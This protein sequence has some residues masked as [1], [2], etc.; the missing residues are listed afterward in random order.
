VRLRS[1]IVSVALLV[2]ASTASRLAA[3]SLSNLPSPAEAE[4]LLD[5]RPDLVALLQQKIAAS[6]LTPDQVRE[7]LQ[8]AGYPPSLLDRILGP[9][10]GGAGSD[11]VNVRTALSAIDQLGIADSCDVDTTLYPDLNQE[12]APPPPVS[13]LNTNRLDPSMTGTSTLAGQPIANNSLSGST[14]GSSL[15]SG[16]TSSIALGRRGSVALGAGT[17]SSTGDMNAV[18]ALS[19]GLNDT[20]PRYRSTN[21]ANRPARCTSSVYAYDSA[22]RRRAAKPGTPLKI[23]GL[24]LFQASSNQFQPNLYGPIDANYKL[25]PGDQL[26]LILTGDVE[27][28]RSLTVTREGFIVLPQVGELNVANLTL[29]DLNELLYDR[30]GKVYSGIKRGPN[31]TTHFSISVSRLRSNQ[32]FVVGDVTQPGSY[33]LSSAG[34]TLSALYAARGPTTEGSM[35]HIEIRRAGKVIDSLDVYDYLLHGDASHDIRL[36]TGDIVFVPVHGP[37]IKVTGQVTRPAIYEMRGSETLADAI[38]NAGGYTAT[39]FRQRIQITRVV[40]PSNQTEPGRDRITMDVTAAAS[41]TGIAPALALT[42]GDSIT[43][44]GISDQVRDRITVS[45]DVWHA[46]TVGFAPGLRLSDAIRLAGGLKPDAYLGEVLIARLEPDSTRIQLRAT[47][48]DSTGTPVEDVVLQENDDIRIFA[49]REF[50]A[51]RYVAITGA[52]RHGGR[53]AYHEGMTMRDLVLLAGGLTEGAYLTEAEIAR[54][55]ENRAGG[56]TATSIRVP[57]DST[58]LFDRTPDGRWLGPPGLP[59]PTS[60]SPAVTLT[61]YDNVLI[62]RQP[63]FE[64]QRTVAIAGEVR[65]PGHYALERK[66]ERISDLIQRSGGLTREGYADGI[67]LYRQANRTGRIGIDLPRVLK[68]AKDRDNLIVQ[69]G[70]SIYIPT[71]SGIVRVIGQVNSPVAVAYVPG[72]DLYYYVQSAGGPTEQAATRHSYVTQPNG[73]VESIS[74]HFLLPD[75]VPTPRPGSVITVPQKPPPGPDMTIPL[76][77]AGASLL[78]ALVAIAIAIK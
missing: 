45:G 74:R 64:L 40:S 35:R 13:G 12:V 66:S 43:V 75:V 37:R 46:G 57:L 10:T 53:Y 59:A 77:G 72:R 20:L 42:P 9:S 26:V 60:G 70:D 18:D 52:V 55:P 16:D 51:R 25:E 6:G 28:S 5:T 27:L 48:R 32:I 23:F 56:V 11:T 44:L 65:F 76:L 34:T 3:Q 24:D 14:T 69:D 17:T 8:A 38:R 54:L 58:Y 68:N 63:D 4:Q 78:S 29:G 7:R 22:A 33:Q 1:L 62:F 71:Y 41:D 19:G 39:A 15:S 49:L 36:E 61:A 47:L 2:T 67:V 50:R 73:K 30:L 21:I 31:A